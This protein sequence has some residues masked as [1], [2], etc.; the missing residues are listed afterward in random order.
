MGLNGADLARLLAAVV[1]SSPDAIIG[2][3][4]D[5]KIISWNRGATQMYQFTASEAIGLDLMNLV[6]EGARQAARV[7]L[8]RVRNGDVLDRHEATRIRKDGTE[9]VVSITVAP[10]LNDAGEITGSVGIAHDVTQRRET[11]DR[12]RFQAQLLDSVRESVIATDLDGVVTY[13]GRGAGRLY[14]YRREEMLGKNIELFVP[15][16]RLEEERTRI[17]H[18]IDTGSWSGRH[19]QLRKSGRPFLA[20]SVISLV[21]DEGGKPVGLI[22]IDRDVTR[23]QQAERERLE[24]EELLRRHE[25]LVSIGTLAAGIA[26]EINNPVGGILMAAQYA[27]SALSRDDARDV[28]EKALADIEDDAKRCREI[29][30]GLLRFAKEEKVERVPCDL[31]EVIQA[32]VSLTRKHAAEHGVQSHYQR[33]E[34]LPKVPLNRTEMEQALV[35]LINNAIESGSSDVDIVAWARA[36]DEQL[37]ITVKDNGAGIREDQIEFLFDPFFTTRREQGGTGLGL[38]LAHAIIAD[39]GGAVDV[40]SSPDKGTTV[41]IDLPLPEAELEHVE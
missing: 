30:R 33:N 16:D 17:Q 10:V 37:T 27:E 35:N 31:N 3:D 4:L 1:E 28:L 20:D 32:A 11:E 34:L 29:V 8:E 13:W 5:G 38:S 36:D 15:P 23:Q 22:G 24:M 40:A 14:G 18:A 19:L 41:T 9:I 12:L 25:R 6:P 39:H 21:T 7:T 26:H 2:V